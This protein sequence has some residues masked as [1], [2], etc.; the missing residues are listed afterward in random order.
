M[1]TAVRQHSRRQR[2]R[3]HSPEQTYW[4]KTLTEENTVF[5]KAP[6]QAVL[7]AIQRGDI[8]R[9]V[10]IGVGGQY[11]A[12]SQVFDCFAGEQERSRQRDHSAIGMFVEQRDYNA[13][14]PAKAIIGDDE[15]GTRTTEIDFG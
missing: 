6:T 11:S 4:Q 13:P 8:I 9:I 1:V 3:A 14:I 7:S 5:F 12:G 10:Q 2:H 15:F